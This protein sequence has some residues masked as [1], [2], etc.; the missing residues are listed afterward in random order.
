MNKTLSSHKLAFLSGI[1]QGLAAPVM[2]FNT[3]ELEMDHRSDLE[4]MRSD[5][6][7]IKSDFNVSIQKASQT[8]P[9]SS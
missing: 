5:M 4:K 6:M 2:L 9:K 3:D 8:S 7:R 1:F